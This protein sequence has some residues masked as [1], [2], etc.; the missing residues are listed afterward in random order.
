V[1]ISRQEVQAIVGRTLGDTDGGA[2]PELRRAIDRRPFH[3][4]RA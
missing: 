3:Q 4:V 1:K 2:L